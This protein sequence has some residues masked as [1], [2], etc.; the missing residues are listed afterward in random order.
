MAH[1]QHRRLP[2]DLDYY[3]MTTLSHEGREKLS[4]VCSSSFESNQSDVFV[5]LSSYV[6]EK[7]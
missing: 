1:Q 3:S 2:D 6:V 5:V 7:L 4:K